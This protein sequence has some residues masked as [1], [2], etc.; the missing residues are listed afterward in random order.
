MNRL[1]VF[2]LFHEV[3]LGLIPLSSCL[4]VDFVLVV[5]VVVVVDTDCYLRRPDSS[6]LQ[7]RY[8][9]VELRSIAVPLLSS[10]AP[11]QTL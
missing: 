11:R 6:H 2:S 7:L 8:S 1:R 4:L 5:L 10:G 3:V 9:I